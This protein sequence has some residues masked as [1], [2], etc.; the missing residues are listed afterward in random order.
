M[1]KVTEMKQAVQA[2]ERAHKAA[3]NIYEIGAHT[4]AVRDPA[5]KAAK[6]ARHVYLQAL[7]LIFDGKKPT[8]TLYLEPDDL[9]D[10]KIE[11]ELLYANVMAAEENLRRTRE[12]GIAPE[13]PNTGVLA[14]MVSV[15][16]K[17]PPAH[18]ASSA[19][20]AAASEEEEERTPLS[21]GHLN[22]A[23]LAMS[24]LKRH[25]SIVEQ[26]TGAL[27]TGVETRELGGAADEPESPEDSLDALAYGLSVIIKLREGTSKGKKSSADYQ[28]EKDMVPLVQG[29]IDEV[30]KILSSRSEPRA[31][32]E[33]LTTSVGKH[34]SSP[35]RSA[36]TAGAM[37]VLPAAAADD[38]VV[39][40]IAA[41]SDISSAGPAVVADPAPTLVQEH[42]ALAQ[43]RAAV[44]A[45][46]Q[47]RA[48][49]QSN[50]SPYTRESVKSAYTAAMSE[51]NAQLSQIESEE[52]T[53]LLARGKA[54][55]AAWMQLASPEHA[56]RPAKLHASA[57]N[58]AAGPD[59]KAIFH[60]ADTG[61]EANDDAP[62]PAP[63]LEGVVPPT[64]HNAGIGH[65]EEVI[66]G[67]ALAP[68]PTHV[69]PVHLDPLPGAGNDAPVHGLPLRA[70]AHLEDYVV[71]HPA[72]APREELVGR[73][74]APAH[75]E[76]H[77]QGQ[78]LGQ[79][80]GQD[81]AQ[82]QGQ[83]LAQG[84]GQDLAQGLGQDLAQG[85]GQDLAQ[86]LGQDLAQGLGQDLAQG[87]GQ[88]L[89]LGLGQDLALG[90]GQ[91]LALGLG[92]DLAQGLGQDLA[93][94]LGQDLAQ[95]L[96][97]DLAQGLGQDLALGLGQ[98]LALG[99]GQDL[100]LGLGQDLAQGLGQGQ[101]QGQDQGQ[102]QGPGHE[103][104]APAPALTFEQEIA[105]LT[106]VELRAESQAQ[107]QLANLRGLLTNLTDDHQAPV[108]PVMAKL[109]AY[110][111][112]INTQV[113]DEEP[114][115]RTSRIALARAAF[116]TEVAGVK[117]HPNTVIQYIGMTFAALGAAILL[118]LA[119]STG[120]GLVL[121]A[122]AA[123]AIELPAAAIIPMLVSGP[124]AAAAG[125][126]MMFFGSRTSEPFS[127]VNHW[128]KALTTAIDLD[129]DQAPLVTNLGA[130]S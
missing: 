100:A 97:Q 80:L 121:S 9:T 36:T 11:G 29:R 96:G 61:P 57:A 112:A 122:T 106:A 18:A 20:T 66:G 12:A 63:I 54:A 113:A 46:E 41:S 59:D 127:S 43:L 69:A 60:D 88:D 104:P 3:N 119:A 62:A 71:P 68:T 6:T 129:E 65:E 4:P 32:S 102:G 70:P 22:S 13:K 19:A 101:G 93:Q 77:G 91:D 82:G 33:P 38:E 17:N 72:P 34:R 64:A 85:Q 90:L 23:K 117:G 81:L 126:G 35:R 76:E 86:G 114:A 28:R 37:A 53:S 39:I 84:L 48:E 130:G 115:I 1:T 25:L 10:L 21:R 128:T 52:K 14:R 110:F 26:Q 49:I 120:L 30:K 42:P 92:Q 95:G 83:D 111:E 98:D 118:A 5:I 109:Y 8:D 56:S 116:D 99:L 16:R 124:V 103:D 47:K 51:I 79:G 94:G 27:H 73:Q 24:S 31:T 125:A 78:D 67:D 2:L 108:I 40:T 107:A 58:E 74:P 44:S 75:E 55:Y 45:L 89:A 7:S 105:R 15:V 50:P 123:A 87:L